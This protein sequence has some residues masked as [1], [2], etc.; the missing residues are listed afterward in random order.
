[1]FL[2]SPDSSTQSFVDVR[3]ARDENASDRAG[4]V[5]YNHANKR[6]DGP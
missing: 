4:Q 3:I 6:W 5:I 2:S 1:M